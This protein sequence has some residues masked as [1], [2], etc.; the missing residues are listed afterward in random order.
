MRALAIALVLASAPTL[1]AAPAEVV[2]RAESAVAGTHFSL[3]E[4]AEVR[5]ADEALAQELR[6]LRIGRSPRAGGTLVLERGALER[7]L[8]KARPGAARVLGTDAGVV[9]RGPLQELEVGEL[10]AEAGHALRRA[11]AAAYDDV[12]LDALRQSERVLLVPE[13]ELRLHAR[14]PASRV[15]RGRATVWVDVSLD[16]RIYQSVPIA[17]AVSGQRKVRVAR[18]ALAAGERVDAD[19]FDVRRIDAAALLDA[20]LPLEAG[21]AGLRLQRSLR[22]GAALTQGVL[23]PAR[24]VHRDEQIRVHATVGA[25]AVETMAVATRDAMP[26]EMIRV[27]S[28]GGEAYAVRVVAP[29]TA[30]TPGGAR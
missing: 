22:A 18:R 30:E 6:A 3:G 17:F 14:P 24:A 1:H 4:I 2:L 21:L 10:E 9:R 12:V 8:A 25:V 19:D 5:A 7:W 20:P 26:G 15:S 11:L 27:R 16:G 13:G 23:A 29:G 28:G